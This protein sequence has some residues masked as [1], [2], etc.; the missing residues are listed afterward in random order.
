MA[1]VP[2][3]VPVHP[4]AA[5][6]KE[7]HHR[8]KKPHVGPHIDAYKT[9]H[10]ETV[11]H[12]SDKWWAKVI[13]SIAL[14]GRIDLNM[15]GCDRSRERLCTGTVPSIPSALVVSRRETLLGSQRAA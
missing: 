12:E 4:V 2:K 5:R 3:P 7:G 6:M 11:G 15:N 10:S 1:D 8:Y 14:G 9:A 13:S